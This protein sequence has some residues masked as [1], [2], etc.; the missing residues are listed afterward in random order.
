MAD[1]TL[2]LELDDYEPGD[3]SWDHSDL[4]QFVDEHAVQRDTF[5]NRPDTGEYDGEPF[6]AEDRRILYRW[7]AGSSSWDPV[8]GMGTASNP[9][10]GTVYRE[11]IDT[12]EQTLTGGTVVVTDNEQGGDATSDVRARTFDSPQAAIDNLDNT[13]GGWSD[14]RANGRIEV[15]P[16]DDAYP[17]PVLIDK[18]TI[19]LIGMGQATHII[20]SGDSHALETTAN[21][22]FIQDMEIDHDG[23]GSYDAVLAGGP[24]EIQLRSVTVDHAPRYGIHMTAVGSHMLNCEVQGGDIAGVRITANE[25][26]C[27]G[28][29][30]NDIPGTGVQIGAT[31]Q[32]VRLDGDLF[33]QSNTDSCGDYGILVQDG[34]VAPRV[35][36]TIESAGLDGARIAGDLGIYDLEVYNSG[37]AGVRLRGAAE[38]NI[39][40][41]RTNDFVQLESGSTKNIVYGQ[42]SLGFNDAGTMNIVNGWGKNGGNPATIG[43]WNGNAEYAH[44]HGATVLDTTTTPHTPYIAVPNGSGGYDWRAIST[45]AA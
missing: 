22:I 4:V 21:D 1:K 13:S 3:T 37:D 14:T 20:H 7:D 2:R 19:Q 44:E 11:A 15:Y 29:S 30:G 41:V 8:T 43:D 24:D 33:P 25:V 12:D 45:T 17:G 18:K 35:D 16:V 26:H 10:P 9:L 28:L 39:V 23:T 32:N 5:A 36:M 34:A 40:R 42:A 27:T 38:R 31:A 6:L